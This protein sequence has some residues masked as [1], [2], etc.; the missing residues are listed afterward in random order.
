MITADKVS[1]E[2]YKK[3]QSTEEFDLAVGGVNKKNKSHIL[4]I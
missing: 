2:G 3:I 4:P 1:T